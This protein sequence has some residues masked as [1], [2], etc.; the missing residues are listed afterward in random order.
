MRRRPSIRQRTPIFLGC[1]GESEV[2]YGAL[3]NRLIN[4][5]PDVHVHIHVEILQPGAGDP[6]ALVQR[7]VQ[8]VDNLERRR[9]AFAHKAILM[10]RGSQKKNRE[11]QTLAARNDI[12][13]LIWQDPD[14]EAFLLRHLEGFQQNRPPAG[15]SFAALT[16]AW[17]NYRKGSTQIQLAD[18]I[19][20]ERIGQARA[21]EPALE[22]F[23]SAIGLGK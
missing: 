11:A 19:N 4:E 9:V 16:K 17:P 14:H 1:E 20:L 8:R 7:A 21:V 12:R 22:A 6:H 10:D 18:R 15:A 3:L 23:L 13:H 5:L 2:G